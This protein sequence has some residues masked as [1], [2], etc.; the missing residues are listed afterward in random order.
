MGRHHFFD[1]QAN[2]IDW[3]SLSKDAAEWSII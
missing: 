3:P 1:F 2:L